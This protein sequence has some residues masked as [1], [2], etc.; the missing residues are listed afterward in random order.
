[1]MLN[2]IKYQFNA[3]NI[4]IFFN[5]VTFFRPF[6]TKEKK[7]DIIYLQLGLCSSKNIKI[8]RQNWGWPNYLYNLRPEQ[9]RHIYLTDKCVRRNE[10]EKTRGIDINARIINTGLVE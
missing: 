10:T 8:K 5:D 2:H 9:S 6:I 1:M 4:Y 7:K 3:A